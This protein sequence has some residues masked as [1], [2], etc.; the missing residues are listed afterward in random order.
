MLLIFLKLFLMQL[1]VALV[2]VFILKKILEYQLIEI[3][4]KRF[5]NYKLNPEDQKL[6][7]IIVL[8][9]SGLKPSIQTRLNKIAEEKFKR[10][11]Q[12]FVKKDKTLRGGIVI[13]LNSIVIDY[14][15]TG[16]LRE[17]RILKSKTDHGN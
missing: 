13:K 7:G 15:V 1:A 4:V 5:E 9:K 2:V 6:N 14:S 12:L 3:G 8:A 16:R 10:P 11:M 17:G